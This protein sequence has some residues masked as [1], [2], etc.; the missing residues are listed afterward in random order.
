MYKNQYTIRSIPPKLD[1]TLRRRAQRTG[2]SLNAVLIDALTVG[3]GISP[4]AEFDDLDWFVG[5]KTLD[6]AF[7][8]NIDWL[9]TV[10]KD[11]Q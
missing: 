10:P 2:K 3:A 5:G 9:D 1:I 6:M 7:D 11:I 4:D 8:Q